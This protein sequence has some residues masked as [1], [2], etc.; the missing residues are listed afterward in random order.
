MLDVDGKKIPVSNLEKVLYPQAEFTK[1]QVIDYY[2]RISPV[3]LPHLKDRPLTL[4][5]YPDGVKGEYFYE[6]NAPKHTPDWIKTFAVAHRTRDGSIRYILVNNLATL[7]WSAN[8][9][10]L[11]LHTFLACV[12]RLESPNMVVFDLDPGAPAGVL[13]CAQVALWLREMLAA[14]KMDCVVKSSGSKGIQLYVPLNTPSSYEA[15]KDFARIM[16]ETLAGQHHDLVTA[17]MSKSVRG[18]RVFIDWSQNSE[19]KTTICVYSL[20]ASQEIP[21]VSIPLTWAEVEKYLKNGNRAGFYLQPDEVL[22]R[23]EK[24]GDLF[25]PLLTKK[26]KIPADYATKIAGIRVSGKKVVRKAS[27]GDTSIQTYEAKRDFRQTKEPPPSKKQLPA[28]ASEL[29]FVIQKHEATR[30]HY[31]FRLEMEGVLRSW[32]VPKGLPTIL[33]DKRLAMH[34]EDHPM[35]YARFEGT[36]PKGNY[37]G[38]TVMVWDIGTYEVKTGDPV[39]AYKKGAIGLRL[40]GKKLKGEWVLFRS[41]IRQGGKEGWIIMKTD[42]SIPEIG[43]R[44]DDTSVLTGRSMKK[45]AADDDAQWISRPKGPK[46]D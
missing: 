29:M 42:N 39:K 22:A 17:N 32:A 26:Q 27:T 40:H 21:Y 34:V 30:L 12:P 18:G 9:A 35:K 45:I 25:A 31:D 1:A 41:K 10:N 23:I 43:P 20:R 19:H 37:G 36:I 5:R 16:A 13:E 11:E 8:L 2:V 38:G 46:K 15:T 33:K 6:K 14:L 3:L 24:V 44:K 28:K 7:V 4:K